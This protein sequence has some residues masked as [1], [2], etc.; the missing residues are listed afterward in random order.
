MTP[1]GGSRSALSSASGSSTSTRVAFWVLGAVGGLL[2]TRQRGLLRSRWAL[3]GAGAAAVLM[4]P[5]LVWQA[6]HQW[7]TF[8]SCGAC[9][10]NGASD[11]RE[12]SRCSWR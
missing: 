6:T 8:E 4:S 2:C 12:S 1:G 9:T 10:N 7:A 11:V 5:D 3:G